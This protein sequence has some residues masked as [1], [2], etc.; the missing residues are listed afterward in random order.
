VLI[1]QED[2]ALQE[3]VNKQVNFIDESLYI[4]DITV[5]HGG[6]ALSNYSNCKFSAGIMYKP[7][8]HKWLKNN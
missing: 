5:I 1:L 8:D 4:Y 3:M 6:L 2:N 7:K